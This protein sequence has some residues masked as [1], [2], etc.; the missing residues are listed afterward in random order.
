MSAPASWLEPALAPPH[1]FGVPPAR[2]QLRGVP[3]DFVV[4]EQLGFEADGAGAHVLLR[5][6]KR[7]ANTE[8]VARALARQVGC[9]V[10]DVG[11]AGLKDRH[12]VA[13]QWFSVPA[14]AV[15]AHAWRGFEGEGFQVLEAHGHARKLPRGALSGNHFSIRVRG[16]EG[17]REA[18]TE[19]LRLIERRGVPNYFG[20]QRF[21]HG[22]GN[23]ARLAQA[24]TARR[25]THMH[26]LMLSSARSLIF[27]AVLAARV[28]EQRWEQLE[29]GDVANLDAR[30]SVFPVA[31][32][33]AELAARAS[34]LELH[35]TGPLWGR[36][37]SAAQGRVLE[38]E[39]QVAAGFPLAC[40]VSV[41]AGMR[42]E[43][44]SLR[45]SVSALRF[46][47]TGADLLLEF[48]LTRGCFAT[49]VLREI[50]S[51]NTESA[52]AAAEDD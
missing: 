11:Y 7:E 40:E 45:L 47:V 28:R 25:G 9:P 29:P 23:L 15:G 46:E 33:D 18:L 52:S 48:F 34:R 3:E 10:R 35:P 41:A 39:Q 1:A 20:P 6:R 50:V 37:S 4:Q 16:I 43:R 12:A 2:G 17:D 8:W 22:G 32:V 19:R 24:E 14:G 21:G 13:L 42:Q 26:A 51:S 5:V 38:L 36:G 30:G 31:A 27:N 49:T 44:R